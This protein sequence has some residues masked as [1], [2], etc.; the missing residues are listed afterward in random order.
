V[1]SIT[2]ESAL[3]VEETA[4]AIAGKVISFNHVDFNRILFFRSYGSKC[5]YTAAR[6]HSLSKIWRTAL[7][8]DVQYAIEVISHNFD[9]MNK[10]E[11]EKVIIHELM[12]IPKSFGGGFV[13]HKG[14]ITTR[15]IESLYRLYVEKRDETS[16]AFQDHEEFAG[17]GKC[18]TP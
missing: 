12:H 18:N 11:R 15:K 5:K 10:E 13:N 4:R 17:V 9:N 7:N 2:Y 3:D 16:S 6:I 8:R 1:V 14:K